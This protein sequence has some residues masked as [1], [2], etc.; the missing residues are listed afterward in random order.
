VVG[1]WVTVASLNSR[2]PQAGYGAISSATTTEQSV[3]VT[4]PRAYT[5]APRVVVSLY[6][7]SYNR[8]LHVSSITATGFTVTGALTS[9]TGTAAIEFEWVAVPV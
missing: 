8:R 9:G 1:W 2:T 5:Y 4:F 6:N 7:A 3:T